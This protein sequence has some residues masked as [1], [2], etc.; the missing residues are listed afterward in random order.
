[1]LEEIKEREEMPA[2]SVKFEV[3]SLIERLNLNVD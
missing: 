3:F 1:L 2:E